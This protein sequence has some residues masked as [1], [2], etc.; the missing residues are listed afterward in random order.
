MITIAELIKN[1]NENNKTSK[2]I[3]TEKKLKKEV[4]KEKFKY[5]S[6]LVLVSA[7]SYFYLDNIHHKTIAGVIFFLVF[8]FIILNKK[9]LISVEDRFLQNHRGIKGEYNFLEYSNKILKGMDHIKVLANIY[10]EGQ[11]SP[12]QIDCILV[13]NNI[14]IIEI[15]KWYGLIIGFMDQKEWSIWQQGKEGKRRSPYFQNK[16]HLRKIKKIIDIEE[17][18]DYYNIIVNMERD[19]IFNI[20]DKFNHFNKNRI[21]ITNNWYDLL[22]LIKHKEKNTGK[23]YLLKQ[24][25]KY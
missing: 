16:N 22:Y 5:L 13:G 6:I 2:F 15:K 9:K 12:N 21:L 19:S 14:Y 7:A 17:K 25:K 20:P 8:I 18:L 1:I 23:K 24:E 4:I 3:K 11:N 10:T